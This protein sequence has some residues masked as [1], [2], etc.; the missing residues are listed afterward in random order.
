[1]LGAGKNAH[2]PVSF[3]LT[4]FLFR[5][6]LRHNSKV[7]W[8]VHFTSTIHSPENLF[9]GKETFPGDSPGVYI[10]AL[11]K[12]YIGDFTNIG[13]KVSIISA[14]HDLRDNNLHMECPPI[15]I[16][17]HCWIGANAVILPSVELGNHTI[18]GANAVVTKSFKNGN[19]VITGNP[20]RLI[21]ELPHL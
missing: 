7:K 14:N 9:I 21:R 4:D 12:V 15:I 11:N 17:R 8:P 19:C 3:Y 6:I 2:A 20:A 1:M 13:P 16:G 18:V 5:K 10:N